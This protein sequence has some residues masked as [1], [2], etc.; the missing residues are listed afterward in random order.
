VEDLGRDRS[1]AGLGRGGDER[2]EEA[3]LDGRVVVEQEDVVGAVGERR[4]EPRVHAPREA[5]VLL[6]PDHADVREG[7][8]DGGGD[9]VRGGVVDDEGRE[10]R[11]GRRRER[12]EAGEGLLRA[13]PRE[14]D[15]GDA[16]GHVSSRR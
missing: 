15:R 9:V 8:G 2:L 14:D 12:P 11:V 5:A 10:R 7:P 4:L 13:V 16:R 6:E 3:R 1:D